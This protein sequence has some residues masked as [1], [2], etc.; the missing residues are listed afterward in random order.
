MLQAVLKESVR[1]SPTA[2]AQLLGV[3]EELFGQW[4]AGQRAMPDSYATSLAT[5]LGVTVEALRRATKGAHSD[6]DVTPA[7]W[8]KL[9]DSRLQPRDREYVAL[10]RHLASLVGQ[11]EQAAGSPS[12]VWDSL[13]D[14]VRKHTEVGAPPREQGRQAARV[15]RT[16]RGLGQGAGGVGE[17]FRGHLRA[18]GVLV[19]ETPLHHSHLEGCSFYVTLPSD[20][21]RPCIFGNTHATTWFR[22]NAILA[23][24][25][26]HL[27][28]DAR[29]SG[30]PSTSRT[31][32]RPRLS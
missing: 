15:L 21:Q 5:M 28:F 3:D 7:I 8:F 19:V 14:S 17:V 13:F 27:I 1:I 25:L 24:E 18:I 4:S 23:H 9:R 20:D 2:C 22:R 31:T 30:W 11:L 6:A 12:V 26:A 29:S 10:V 16:E 32:S